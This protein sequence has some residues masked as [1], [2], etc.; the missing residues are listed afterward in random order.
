M[1][2]GTLHPPQSL[3]Y[4]PGGGGGGGHTLHPPQSLT[5]GP[6]DRQGITAVERKVPDSPNYRTGPI[7]C[8]EGNGHYAVSV[9]AQCNPPTMGEVME[10]K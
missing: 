5:Y 8:V 4:G 3:T 2:R 10:W 6:G 7:R 9:S 1:G